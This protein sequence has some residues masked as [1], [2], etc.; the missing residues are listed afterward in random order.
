MKKSKKRGEPFEELSVVKSAGYDKGKRRDK[1]INKRAGLH[2]KNTDD[3]ET[4]VSRSKPLALKH[5]RR[6]RK[7]IPALLAAL[8]I[9][10]VIII[11][12]SFKPPATFD[13]L[14]GD[15]RTVCFETPDD[16]SSPEDHTVVET[17][18]YLCYTL[19][20]A[21]YWSS[22]MEQTLSALFNIKQNT[23]NYK[24]YYNGNLISVDIAKGASTSAK[25]FCQTDKAVLWR[26]AVDVNNTNGFYTDWKE[27][28]P[29]GL[30]ISEFKKKR[31]LPPL[32]F[33][34][35]VLNENT[36]L[37]ADE[38]GVVAN[39]DGT[40]SITAD[41]N[42]NTKYGE[43]NNACSAVYYYKQQMA[44]TGGLSQLP[45]YFYTNVTYTFDEN[46][47]VLSFEIND[48]Y[49]ATLR[50]PGL[51][52]VTS[53]CTSNTVTVFSYDE[54][55]CANNVY[56]FFK[57]YVNSYGDATDDTVPF[58]V[59]PTNCLA[60]AFASV[61]SDGAVFNLDLGL[62][63]KTVDGVLAVSLK[64]GGLD[65]ISAR[66]GNITAHVLTGS[67]GL[68]LYL[69]LGQSKYKV[70]LGGVALP[71]SADADDG[72][73]LSGLLDS[74]LGGDF[75]YDSNSGLA[76][77]RSK[78][79]LFGID[80]DI[81][82]AFHADE[83]KEEIS[84][85]DV[86]ANIKYGN[87]GVDATL[88]F[89][90]EKDKP[91]D[92]TDNAKA[93]Y[94]DI[95]NDGVTVGV[96]LTL[97]E[98][99]INGIAKIDLSEGKFAGVRAKLGDI[100]VE[101]DGENLYIASGAN[102]YKLGA[103]VFGGA[104][105]MSAGLDFDLNSILSGILENIVIE[106][107]IINTQV[108]GADI[109]IDIFGEINVS[110][111]LDIFGGIGLEA[112]LSSEAIPS[113]LTEKDKEQYT[114]ILN[115]GIT[116]GV[117]LTLGDTVVNGIAKIDLSEGKFAGVRAK[118][119]DITV[120]YDG[121]NLYIASGANKY[122]LGA[123]VF[124]GV[125]V[126]PTSLDFDLKSIL[127]GILENIVIENG[128]IK[129]RL[130]GADISSDLS[131]VTIDVSLDIFGGIKASAYLDMFGGIG[132]EAYLSS[133]AVPAKLTEK[134][135]EQYTDILNDGIT[136]G[137]NLTVDGKFIQGVAKVDLAGGELVGVRA[138]LGDAVVHY[139]DGE[140]YVSISGSKIKLP[141]AVLA[142]DSLGSFNVGGLIEEIL[143][144]INIENGIIKTQAFGADVSLDIFG[145]IKAEV[146]YE[147]FSAKIK[148]SATLS[149][150]SAPAKLT[151][152]EKEQYVDVTDSFSVSGMLSV[153]LGGENISL[154]VNNLA[155][156]FENQFSF[157]LDATLLLNNTYN[158]FYIEYSAG[159][160]TVTYGAV[161]PMP[162]GIDGEQVEQN[163]IT[164]QLNLDGG[165]IDALTD[166]IV[167]VYNRVLAV[168][169]E[170]AGKNV[171]AANGLSDILDMLGIAKDG[172]DG[173][174]E[175]LG[176]LAIPSKDGKPD[177]Q[178]IIKAI[179]LYSTQ[180]G[181]GI[182]LGNIF[183]ELIL[184][185]NGVNL[186]ANI[187][188]GTS[189]FDLN[190]SEVTVYSYTDFEVPCE[191]PLDRVGLI[192]MLD[193][194]GATADM[195]LQHQFAINLE[196][197]LYNTEPEYN[198]CGNIKYKFNALLE[199][200]DGGKIPVSY[201]DGQLY[202]SNDLY[203]HFNLALVAQNPNVDKSL[204]LDV[205]ILDGH[206]SGTSA[207]LTTGGY[208]SDNT[209]LDFYVSVSE[210]PDGAKGSNPLKFYGSMNEVLTIA[211]MGVAMLNLQD[212]ETTSPEVNQ[213]VASIY[214]LLNGMLIE[215]YIPTVKSQ[216]ASLG[217][218]LIPNILK[219]DLSSLLNKLIAEYESVMDGIENKTEITEGNF[220]KKAAYADGRLDVA[221]NSATLFGVPE[222]EDLTF[223]I[224][225]TT[226]A[227]SLISGVGLE[228]IYFGD[229][230]EKKLNLSAGI[231]YGNIPK[232]DKSSGLK[233]YKNFDGLDKLLLAA[234]GSATHETT[235][236]ER[237]A[238]YFADYKLNND[239]YVDGELALLLQLDFGALSVPIKA[240]PITINTLY[241]NIDENNEVSF[242]VNL[243]YSSQKIVVDIITD[244]ATVDISIRKDM[245]YIRKVIK[246]GAT[247]YRVMPSNTFMNDMFNQLAYV[248]SFSS[249]VTNL[250]DQF[251]SKATEKVFPTF[252]D[253][254]DYVDKFVK[255]YEYSSSANTNMWHF[256][257]N[258]D[259]L[260]GMAGMSGLS[261][262]DI[263]FNGSNGNL[264]SLTLDG[265]LSVMY[266][267][268]TL[269]YLNPNEKFID[270]KSDKSNNVTSLVADGLY[271]SWADILGGD[272]FGEIDKHFKWSQLAGGK[273]G[274]L[275]YG[276]G[277]L[278]F[279]GYT[280]IGASYEVNGGYAL[281]T[282][283]ELNEKGVKGVKLDAIWMKADLKI[284]AERNGGILAGYKY[285]LGASGNT[286][287]FIG[288]DDF[289]RNMEL[290]CT[291]YGFV[292]DNSGY[293][294]YVED[295]Q[296]TGIE[297]VKL[298]GG[299]GN[300]SYDTFS[301]NTSGLL[302]NGK[303]FGHVVLN[304][305]LSIG[306]YELGTYI[307]AS[308]RIALL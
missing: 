215:N 55:D 261:D 137:V 6:L 10:M 74:L 78:I 71:V 56:D 47:R 65:T 32:E 141:V 108:F 216:F 190:I 238:G 175:I 105:V 290:K 211:S 43:E 170:I 100:T 152:K 142:G 218:S 63:G 128:I 73:M 182:T 202:V 114:D 68:E 80:I 197:T 136:V 102:K 250:A 86:K 282:L 184:N 303:T 225:K 240:I 237:A 75:A 57:G 107:G 94:T 85:I 160:L 233:D 99:V 60:G 289:I 133:E 300:Y 263:K 34:V 291:A 98:K 247:T 226:G 193:Y 76:T 67:G 279:G 213:T 26:D 4:R 305:T 189:S 91:A 220:I 122:K 198:E 42:V 262:I 227:K 223:Y 48:S 155:V 52:E 296:H 266:F 64:D 1:T 92:L 235:E 204:Y 103:E 302:K 178:A 112:Y 131:D 285:T 251:M 79:S 274:Y 277:D 158:N 161:Q 241:I 31:G 126:M 199:Y 157:K 53:P 286:V 275:E 248:L 121:E 84:L 11:S 149:T 259:T 120:H 148:A 244:S 5:K 15:Y 163:V 3:D 276:G 132:L 270:G 24:K 280:Y 16:G 269:N 252:D 87:I 113:K 50:I 13:D 224:T 187:K 236:E 110:A 293:E 168:Y 156:S 206:P 200:D 207:G 49:E 69:S 239:Y 166:A 59:N 159:V 298:L 299:N 228:N 123:E 256:V 54:A 242:D 265:A 264:N 246:G 232:P 138:K 245:V 272:S 174:S 284:N 95:L 51:G 208:T 18:G 195:L 230:G 258:G 278:K 82:F 194:L 165:D 196:G 151:D 217:E 176:K 143:N 83:E 134:D 125:A 25:Q 304:L 201:E 150:D 209:G 173:L 295:N 81:Q 40:Y 88:K 257:L 135:K 179:A 58:A 147:I 164:V 271:Y 229:N 249:T 116:V 181:M 169:N 231:T 180:D 115:D 12:G 119:G 281:G 144:N 62:G 171:Q 104:A 28:K 35:Y 253:Y 188:F 306:N 221:L 90:E 111:Y 287:D 118:L 288:N 139:V 205:Y 117:N 38:K 167:D 308:S 186:G 77:L 145:G 9:A 66:L 14:E 154:A 172:V 294:P 183:A 254:G 203:V 255:L 2:G 89:G 41:L 45:T 153:T 22:E 30:T 19:K 109:S 307:H 93:L 106:N 162:I 192:E 72:D 46:Y 191:N 97:G 292:N 124:G 219:T 7:A 127:S 70:D 8:S 301:L 96:N 27:D 260:G 177:M 101:Y 29:S 273:T 185:G 297:S 234:V 21:P 20:N 214:E 33:S 39:G 17:V 283:A 36:I 212:I 268:G 37:N 130:S 243:S 44:V 267:S 140:L 222:Y 23:Y 210:F 146:R 61:L 129:T